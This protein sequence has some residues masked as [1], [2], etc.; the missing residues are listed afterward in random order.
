MNDKEDG[1]VK[2]E[3]LEKI[4]LAM[5]KKGLNN[6]SL[7]DIAKEIGT[8]GRMILYYFK[9]YDLLINSVFIYLS[10]K[11]KDT[12]KKVFSENRDKAFSEAADI[13]I[14]QIF[15]PE[16]RK[17]LLLFLELYTKAARDPGKYKLFFKEVLYNWITEIETMISSEYKQNSKYYSAMIISFYRGL[18]MDWLASNDT[19][20]IYETN[21]A[22]I[23]LISGIMKDHR[24]E[25]TKE[26]NNDKQN[27]RKRRNEEHS[28]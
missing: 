15:N 8:S 3:I 13:Y 27:R 14:R 26:K 18:L 21:K 6:L 7:R 25:Y 4:I 24:T 17:A 5:S 2:D 23:E 12:L 11:H 1:E 28:K 19:D 20:R 9:S 22:F 10:T 16:N